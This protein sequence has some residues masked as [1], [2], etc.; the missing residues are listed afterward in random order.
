MT[1][2]LITDTQVRHMNTV[3]LKIS[4]G[5]IREAIKD[6]RRWRI[7][8]MPFRKVMGGIEIECYQ[9]P[10]VSLLQLKYAS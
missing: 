8:H 6:V 4:H 10:K 7:R 1:L 3:K 9:N 2:K 5:H